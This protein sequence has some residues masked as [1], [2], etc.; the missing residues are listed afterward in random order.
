MSLPIFDEYLNYVPLPLVYDTIKPQFNRASVDCHF[1]WIPDQR[2]THLLT[3]S[4]KF[5]KYIFL[6]SLHL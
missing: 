2:K 3:T 5:K 4:F 6:L 1:N